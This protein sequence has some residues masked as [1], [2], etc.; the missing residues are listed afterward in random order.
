M[1]HDSSLFR[2][3]GRIMV[4]RGD[5][6]TGPIVGL[7]RVRTLSFGFKTDVIGF[8]DADGRDVKVG[9]TAWPLAESSVKLRRG[10]KARCCLGS[11]KVAF[12]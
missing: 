8:E 12:D 2:D 3:S 4:R 1:W 9:E 6:P 11:G 5:G 10:D 7:R